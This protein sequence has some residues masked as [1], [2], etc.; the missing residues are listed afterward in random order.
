MSAL[1]SL[2]ASLRNRRLSPRSF[3][4][5]SK[6]AGCR[7]VRRYLP[8]FGET[9]YRTGS[10]RSADHHT[11]SRSY[12]TLAGRWLAR[13]GLMGGFGAFSRIVVSPGS[14]IWLSSRRQL[15]PCWDCHQCAR[16]V[17]QLRA[18]PERRLRHPDRTVPR[19]H[20]GPHQPQ[21]ARRGRRPSASSGRSP[22]TVS[23]AQF[24]PSSPAGMSRARPSP[25]PSVRARP[26]T[27]PLTGTARTR[28]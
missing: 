27:A 8:V 26:S 21:G 18:S 11:R 14:E 4:A 12:P 9:D 2:G 10:S 28:A 19:H 1:R 3:R 13:N 24:P 6:V 5:A 17:P 7:W 23:Y 22:P 16:L 20:R 15:I 25:A